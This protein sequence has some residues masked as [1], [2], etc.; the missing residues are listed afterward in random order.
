MPGRWDL[1]GISEVKDCP[2]PYHIMSPNPYLIAG[3]IAYL[4]R[5]HR[6]CSVDVFTD[7]LQMEYS[8]VDLDNGDWSTVGNNPVQA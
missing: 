5:R 3:I 1:Q 4:V 7:M 2:H 8:F 6:F